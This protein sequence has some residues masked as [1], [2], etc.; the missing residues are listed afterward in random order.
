MLQKKVNFLYLFILLLDNHYYSRVPFKYFRPRF[1][2]PNTF[3]SDDPESGLEPRIVV[4]NNVPYNDEESRKLMDK[5][6]DFETRI[7]GRKMENNV[8]KPN[9]EFNDIPKTNSN[10]ANENI[11]SN[12]TENVPGKKID[13]ETQG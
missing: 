8:Q 2:N 7:N 10:S 5:R 13:Q 12:G 1:L 11:D 4:D 9:E 3:F 6:G